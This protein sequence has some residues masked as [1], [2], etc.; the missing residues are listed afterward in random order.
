MTVTN[1][2]LLNQGRTLARTL[3]REGRKEDAQ[4]VDALLQV[5]DASEAEAKYLTTGQVAQRVGVSR[6][7]VVNWIEKGV[8]PAIRL[9]GRRMI[10]ASALAR[11]ARIERILDE[12]DAERAP[13]KPDEIVELVGR[14]RGN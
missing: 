14:G 4:T 6:Q 8:V 7:T 13:G 10:P 1:A 2:N 12:L 3:R 5:V 11:F 9:G